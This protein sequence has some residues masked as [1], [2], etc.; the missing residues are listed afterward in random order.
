[1]KFAERPE[2]ILIPLGWQIQAVTSTGTTVNSSKI[3]AISVIIGK[4]L[5]IPM[6]PTMI[7]KTE[8]P[9]AITRKTTASPTDNAD[10][11][12]NESATPTDIFISNFE[13]NNINLL[14]K[15]C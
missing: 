14:Y 8:I 15:W 9:T 4:N 12:F 1:M 6:P 11:N 13:L 5:G 7:L 10:V 3:D 2:K